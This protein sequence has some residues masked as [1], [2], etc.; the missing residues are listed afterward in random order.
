MDIII[1]NKI[2]SILGRV[3]EADYEKGFALDT[4]LVRDLMADS[5]KLITMVIE[6]ETEFDITF[7]DDTL[8]F[9]KL[10]CYKWICEKTEELC[11]EK[12]QS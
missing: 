8:I 10:S 5:L 4:D 7:P 12:K 9:S 1:K 3:F 2:D 11:S 6:L